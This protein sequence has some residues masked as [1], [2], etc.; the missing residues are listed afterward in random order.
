MA[1]IQNHDIAPY[2]SRVC[3]VVIEMIKDYVERRLAPS[4]SHDARLAEYI[5]HIKAI[6]LLLAQKVQQV[7]Q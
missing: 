5:R 7:A 3:K 4:W 1:L 6:H 2:V